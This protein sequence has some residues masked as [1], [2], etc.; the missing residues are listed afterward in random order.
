MNSEHDTD[1]SNL[2]MIWDIIYESLRMKY[3][4]FY[5]NDFSKEFEKWY[6][7]DK[8]RLRLNYEYFQGSWCLSM[9]YI[10]IRLYDMKS[11]EESDE[12]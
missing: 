3:S 4:R 2:D 5:L 8:T 7:D 12:F 9:V 1:K 6:D 11:N 10:D